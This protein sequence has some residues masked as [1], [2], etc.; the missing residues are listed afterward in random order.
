MSW[1]YWD[2]WCDWPDSRSYVMVQNGEIMA[3][4]AVVPL[5]CA[6]E[7]HRIK[8][9][10]IIDW[11]AD[12]KSVGG[13]VMLMKQIGKMADA[14]MAVGGSE[15]TLRIFPALGAKKVGVVN[16]Y[17]RPLRPLRRLLAERKSDWRAGARFARALFWSL[18]APSA[19]PAGWKARPVAANQLDSTAFSR[20]SASPGSAVFERS[21]ASL[22]YY[23]R[24]PAVDFKL[25]VVEKNNVTRGYFLL[26]LVGC[27]AR[28]VESWVDSSDAADWRALHLLAVQEARRYRE[29]TEVATMC[30]DPVTRQ[31]IEACGFHHRGSS[32]LHLLDCS[33]RGLPTQNL[34]VQMMEGDSSFLRD[35]SGSLWS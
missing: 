14:V 5:T 21:T 24:C 20:P 25:N 35:S 30:S 3:H 33:K 19:I 8:V 1:K 6:W 28:I 15:M 10:R 29:V 31:S 26:T 16:R 22:H 17:V 4:G 27:Q 32:E 11:A 34:R 12:A 23:L 2:E 9:V 7:G 18:R 13:G